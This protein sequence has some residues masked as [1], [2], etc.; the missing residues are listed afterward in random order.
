MKHFKL[1][2]LAVLP[3]I[4]GIIPFGV[5]MGAAFSSAGLSFLQSVFMNISVYAGAAQLASLDL[6]KAH[7]ALAVVVATGLV[8]NLRFLL[9]SAA[10]APYLK[11]SPFIIKFISA[12]TLT[13]QSYAVMSA[14]QDKFKTNTEA[15]HFYLGTA[16][17]MML[18]WDTSVLAGYIFG[19]FAP[20]SLSLDFAV[21]LSFLALLAPT[22][23]TKKHIGVAIFSS[24]LSLVF[25]GLP[26]KT[27][28]LFTALI[29]MVLAWFL[30]NRKLSA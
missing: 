11:D 5:V 3:I 13:D 10:M 22:L 18:V 30:I 24:V 21:P 6:M 12:F 19:N 28:L 2:F 1:G 23:K 16:A 7:A 8:I 9:Y 20:A 26:L 15:V 14:N 27:G 25:Y 17:A 29:S 4:S